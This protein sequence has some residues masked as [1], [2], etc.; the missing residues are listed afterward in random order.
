MFCAIH[1]TTGLP[2]DSYAILQEEEASSASNDYRLAHAEDFRLS[3]LASNATR[4]GLSN[5]GEFG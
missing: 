2:L 4:G 1:S 3:D 5:F